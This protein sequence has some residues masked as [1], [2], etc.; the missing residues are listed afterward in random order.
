MVKRKA[1]LKR[2]LDAL[3][4]NKSPINKTIHGQNKSKPEESEA[5]SLSN[6]ALRA[7]PIEFLQP[8]KYQPR[9]D[10]GEEGLQELADSI[11]VQ[12]VIQPVVIRPLGKDSYEIIAGERRWRAAQKAGLED[13]PVIIKDVP[14]EAAIAMSLIENIQREDLNA[15]DEAMALRRLMQEFDLTHQEVADAVGKSRTTVSNLIRLLN[16]NEE[17]RTLLERGDIE[18]G[19]GRALLSLSGEEQSHTARLVADKGLSVRETEVLVRKLLNPTPTKAKQEKNK[20]IKRLETN[21]SEYIGSAVQVQHNKKG[22][23]K[24]VIQYSTL[25]ELDGILGKM[26]A[27]SA[28]DH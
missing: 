4:A 23:G 3:L 1:G 11:K 25:D 6:D 18:M 15:V 27:A 20:D 16:L 26:G 13:I 7:I 2:G 24:L 19:H 12:G 9:R 17:T 28:I 14:D 5:G 21:L 10:M 22:K 8:G